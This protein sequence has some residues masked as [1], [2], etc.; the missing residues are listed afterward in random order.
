MKNKRKI[1]ILQSVLCV[2]LALVMLA[3]NGAVWYFSGYLDNMYTKYQAIPTTG[4]TVTYE[5]ALDHGNDV[6]LRIL[7]EGSVLLKNENSALPLPADL[8]Q[9]N[10]FGWRSS[11]MVFGGAGSG[12]VDDANAVSLQTA[13]EERGIQVNQELLDLYTGFS[14]QANASDVGATDFTITELPV[15]SYT[16]DV[17]SRAKEFSDTAIITISRMGGEGNDLPTDMSAF[18][19]SSDRHYLELSEQEEAMIQLVCEQFDRVILLVN[20][21]HAMELG[22]VEEYPIDA[23]LWIGCPGTNG[24]RGVADVLT[25]AVSPSGRLVDTYAYDATSAPSFANFGEFAY[26]NAPELYYV[27]YME[28]IYVGY[29]YYETRGFTDG[30][31]WYRSQV[32]YPFGY[33][34]SYTSFQQEISSFVAMEQ[35]VVVT[36]N[37]TNTGD[38]AGKD[39][40]QL[41]YT[42]PYTPGGIEKSHV[43]LIA[44][45]KTSTLEPGESESVTLSFHLEDMASYDYQQ[46]KAY[47]LEAGDY[48]VRLMRNAHEELDSETITVNESVVYTE[49]Q[50]RTLE[51]VAATNRFDDAAVNFTTGSYLSRSDW[52]GTWPEASNASNTIAEDKLA[53]VNGNYSA[54]YDLASDPNL[55]QFPDTPILTDHTLTSEEIEQVKA[56]LR[57]ILAGDSAAL[58]ELDA[59][60]GMT[61]APENG[62]DLQKQ[63]VALQNGKLVFGLM[64]HFPYE[65]PTWDLLISQM[66]LQEISNL[67]TMGGYRTA[68]VN[69][70]EKSVTMDIDGPAGM[71]PFLDFG[72]DIQPGVGYPTE[73]TLA[74]TWNVEL[75]QEM[76]QAAAQFANSQNVSGWYAPAMNI[77]RSPFAGRN[78]EYYSEDSLLSGKL[79]A[80]TTAGAMQQGVWVYLKHFALN[81]QELHRDQGLCT[82][83]NEQAIREIYLK[84]FQITVQEGGATGIMS[85][86]NL[87]GYLWAGASRALCTDV[88]RTEW[89]FHGTVIT[90]FYMNWGSTYMNARQGI[91]AGNDLYL[92]PFQHEAVTLQMLQSSDPL[93]QAAVQSCK[94]ILYM[95]SRGVQNIL[96]PTSSWRP[97]WVAGNAVGGMLLV[98]CI[99]WLVLRLRKN[100][101]DSI[102]APVQTTPDSAARS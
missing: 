18:G 23:V 43:N 50:P 83:S 2:L 82:F 96:V 97:L 75:A 56:E 9:V 3:A 36:V 19:G 54:V 72:I 38:T 49:G 25:G 90:D 12:F 6:S 68:E 67:I 102:A 76:G 34:L 63:Y 79:G 27:N 37:V 40:V 29:R 87:V 46:A 92:N 91:L 61:E 70:I 15:S 11:K 39:V 28:G 84:P 64:N 48:A 1:P 31:D 99:V 98:A 44:F 66:S 16:D 22:F 7:Q 24:L 81:D 41:Y 89:G 52:E 30:E 14:S 86:F 13:L 62:T 21:S 32:Q 17:L 51:Q 101:K 95:T 100:R 20:S 65:S 4:E 10:L 5:Q 42:P 59:V 45:A 47:V 35:D 8:Q 58:A 26:A 55:S 71:Q 53:L 69:S 80:A 93:S 33:G 60:E 73:V 77:H 88:L 94:N 78:F 74:S 57:T 85:A